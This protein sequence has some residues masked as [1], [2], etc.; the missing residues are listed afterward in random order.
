MEEP[1]A[2]IMPTVDME[3]F[4]MGRKSFPGIAGGTN[5]TDTV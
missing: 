5:S 2:L 4:A 3:K 1:W